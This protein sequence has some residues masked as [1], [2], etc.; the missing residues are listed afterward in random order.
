MR[1]IG[2]GFNQPR[3]I[4]CRM[5][6]DRTRVWDMARRLTRLKRNPGARW[7]GKPWAISV[8]ETRRRMTLDA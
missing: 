2:V 1:K 5:I 8:V 4:E 6:F 3:V 7:F